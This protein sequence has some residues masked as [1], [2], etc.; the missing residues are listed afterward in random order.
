MYVLGGGGVWF[1]QQLLWL[2]HIWIKQQQNAESNRWGLCVSAALNAILDHSNLGREAV[3]LPAA[4]MAS[5]VAFR[6]V[7][8]LFCFYFCFVT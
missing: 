2:A 6:V 1:W 8:C 3:L 7:Q 4:E 5:A